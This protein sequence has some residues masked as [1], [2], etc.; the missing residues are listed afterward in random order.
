MNLVSGNKLRIL[1]NSIIL[2]FNSSSFT[3]SITQLGKTPFNKL[4]NKVI[5]SLTNLGINVLQTLLNKIFCSHVSIGISLPLPVFSLSLSSLLFKL[6]AFTKTLL[7]AL[8]PK[9]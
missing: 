5:S 6:P 2:F 7:S 3:S 4:L 8:K 9:S 1:H